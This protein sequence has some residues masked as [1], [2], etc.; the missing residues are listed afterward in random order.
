MTK[1]LFILRRLYLQFS[2]EKGS[3]SFKYSEFKYTSRHLKALTG[4][5]Y[6]TC[7]CTLTIFA[8]VLKSREFLGDITH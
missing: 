3:N 6:N 2:G 4:I 8:I 7:A 5:V 1:S